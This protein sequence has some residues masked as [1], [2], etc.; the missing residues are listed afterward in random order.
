[1]Y[2]T[3]KEKADARQARRLR[4]S[5]SKKEREL[6]RK[7]P[8]VPALSLVKSTVAP[9]KLHRQIQR[10]KSYT[11]VCDGVLAKGNQGK[12]GIGLLIY[13]S[14]ELVGYG[15]GTQFIQQGT[16]NRAKLVSLWKAVQAAEKLLRGDRKKSVQIISDSYYALDA[17]RKAP[18][19]SIRR[20]ARD[21]GEPVKNTDLILSLLD[22]YVEYQGQL[23]LTV[24]PAA[25]AYTFT[26]TAKNLA[27]TAIGSRIEEMQYDDDLITLETIA[28]DAPEDLFDE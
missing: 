13:R 16:S 12:V 6:K 4:K 23:V 11:I 24:I 3:M 8:T 28:G 2:K 22:L 17:M 18:L 5:A 21:N 9:A 7:Q 25:A 27:K 20:W 15:L 10:D 26:D 1:M 19:N 14:D